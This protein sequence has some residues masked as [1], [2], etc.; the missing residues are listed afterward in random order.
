MKKRAWEEALVG[1]LRPTDPAIGLASKRSR[2]LKSA[3]IILPNS[4]V[5]DVREGPRA[6]ARLLRVAAFGEPTHTRLPPKSEHC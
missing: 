5:G 6:F 4:L 2:F 1:W 3:H